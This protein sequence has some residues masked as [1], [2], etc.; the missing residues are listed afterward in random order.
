MNKG[1]HRGLTFIC[2]GATLYATL[3]TPTG[4]QATAGVLVVTGGREVRV[5]AHRGQAEL[6][7]RLAAAGLAAFRFD[8]R[9]VGDSEGDDAGFEGSAPDLHAA[10]AA[11]RAACPALRRVVGWGNCDAATALVLHD[12]PVDA[13]VLGNPWVVEADAGDLPPPAAIRARYLR[14][15]RDP[16]AWRALLSGAIDVRRLAR[17]LRR[18]AAPATPTPLAARVFAALDARPTTILVAERDNTGAA[19]LAACRSHAL[20]QAALVRLPS[21]SHSFAGE[22]EADA[23]FNALVAAASPR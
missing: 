15:L 11:F 22:T 13:R 2:E 5:G 17:G 14:R 16:A 21:P 9:G 10:L 1:V 23:L 6:G 12:L 19:F 18:A 4:P 8:R 7:A 20:G 3:D